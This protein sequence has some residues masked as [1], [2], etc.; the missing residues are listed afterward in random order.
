MHHVRTDLTAPFD[1]LFFPVLLGHALVLLPAFH[2]VQPG[3]QDFHGHLPVLKL[4]AFVLAL[5]H[6]SR[7]KMRH[8]HRGIGG[9]HTLPARPGRTENIDTQIRR[10]DVDFNIFFN[11][12]NHVHRGKRGVPSFVGIK[13]RD[14]HEPVHPFFALQIPV[15]HIAFNTQSRAFDAGPLTGE[16]IQNLDLAV[17]I[18][19]PA[20][21]HPKKH[22]GPVTGFGAAGA[23]VDAQDR[24]VFIERP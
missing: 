8:T 23:G 13:R 14:A 7:R 16:D 24:V 10:V 11:F 20:G 21:V 9:V 19:A 2:F 12:R 17:M 15:N 22:I 5:D 1:F 3:P 18:I 6:D 4:G